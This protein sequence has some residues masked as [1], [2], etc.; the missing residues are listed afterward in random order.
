MTMLLN[1]HNPEFFLLVFRFALLASECSVGCSSS[2]FLEKP[3]GFL[4]FSRTLQAKS[5][6]IGGGLWPG[7][8]DMN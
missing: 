4:N 3:F 7:S 1:S 6:R 2:F 8:C 5:L